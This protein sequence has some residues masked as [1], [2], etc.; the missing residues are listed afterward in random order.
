M[1]PDWKV[2]Q[3]FLPGN[4]LK[5][6]GRHSCANPPTVEV[7]TRF[8]RRGVINKAK[9]KLCARCF[10]AYAGAKVRRDGVIRDVPGVRLASEIASDECGRS[11]SVGVGAEER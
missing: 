11:S 6:D 8:L 2:A 7:E 10:V 5:C 9:R 3:R 4:S 1:K